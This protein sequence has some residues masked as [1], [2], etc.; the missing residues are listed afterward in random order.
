MKCPNCGSND[1]STHTSETTETK[2]RGCLGWIMWIIV[3]CFTFGLILII[4]FITNNKTKTTT[5]TEAVCQSCGK[6]WR[7]FFF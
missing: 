1:V 5:R 3:T 4:P 2:E 7:V 6:R